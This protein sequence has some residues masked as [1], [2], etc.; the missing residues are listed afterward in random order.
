MHDARV[1]GSVWTRSGV[2]V[3]RIGPVSMKPGTGTLRWNGRYRSGGIAYSGRY[4]FKVFARN[5]Y[6][7]VTLAQNF[8]VRR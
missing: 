4:V 5:G 3:R 1:T 7:P 2:L 6:G 8:A